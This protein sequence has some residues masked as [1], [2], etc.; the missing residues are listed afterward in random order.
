MQVA[1][2]SNSIIPSK[3]ANSV[4]VVNMASAL[5]ELGHDVTLYAY[6]RPLEGEHSL[7]DDEALT[8]H[9][10]VPPNFRFAPIPEWAVP[11]RS[12]VAALLIALRQR[13][14]D[15]EL[16]IGRNPKACA[17][18]ALMGLPTVF[19]TH[20]PL[21]HISG[22]DAALTRLALRNLAFRAVVTISNSLRDILLKETSWPRERLLVAHDGAS[23]LVGVAPARLG[24]IGQPQIGYVGHLYEGRGIELIIELAR[25]LPDADFHLIGGFEEDIVC[26][27]NKST[28]LKNLNFV[29]HVPPAKTAAFRLGCDILLAPYQHDTGISGG[30]ITS[31]WMSP[32]KIF[33]YMAA[34]KAFVASDLP[35][36][37]EVLRADENCIMIPP[38]SVD[39]WEAALQRLIDDPDLRKSLGVTALLDF[40]TRYSWRRRAETIVN[41]ALDQT[42]RVSR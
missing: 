5:A 3:W 17:L 34:G 35:V 16:V 19:E 28:H 21:K 18:A 10:G 12:S 24:R 33:E 22:V 13:L 38:D 15:C 8:A 6:L 37:H 4:H 9:Y 29:G 7:P 36:L 20:R 2:F 11:A 40:E 1:Y 42:R 39:A 23:A 26:W 25:R 41:F 31:S 14:G 27:R 32:L 30:N